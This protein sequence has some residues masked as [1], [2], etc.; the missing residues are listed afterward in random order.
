MSGL[1]IS[2]RALSIVVNGTISVLASGLKPTLLI[3]TNAPTLPR[4]HDITP[5]YS[6][7]LT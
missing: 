4:I 7:K 6:L 1:L 5:P 3:F 2:N